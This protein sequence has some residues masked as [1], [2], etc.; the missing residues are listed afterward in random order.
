M[1]RTFRTVLGASFLLTG[2]AAFAQ[3]QQ[4]V[5]TPS[6]VIG[7]TGDYFS[8]NYNV[9]SS[10]STLNVVNQQTGSVTEQDQSGSYW[11]TQNGTPTTGNPKYFVLDLG[12]PVSISDIDLFNTHNAG[13]DDRGTGDFAI[14]ASNSITPDSN[15]S[16]GQDLVN[17]ATIVNGTLAPA[18]QTVN[19]IPAQSFSP[20]TSTAYQYIEFEDLTIGAA[21]DR[22]FGAAGGGLNEIRVFT[23]EPAALSVLSMTGVFV[24]GRRRRA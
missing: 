18:H 23:P 7:G 20:N 24:L 13:Y 22:G 14:L 6:S 19:P 10:F 21:G 12:S 4:V 1:M 8:G 3:A 15:A 16:F 2:A 17:P 5:L 9:A 11:L